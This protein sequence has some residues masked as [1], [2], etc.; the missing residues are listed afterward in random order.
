M[1]RVCVSGRY[2]H[3]VRLFVVFGGLV[4]LADVLGEHVEDARGPLGLGLVEELRAVLYVGRVPP[5]LQHDPVFQDQH[6]ERVGPQQQVGQQPDL[7][8]QQAADLLEPQ[9]VGQV[10]PAEARTA[11]HLEAGLVEAKDL[12]EVLLRDCRLLSAWPVSARSTWRSAAGSP[13]R[14]APRPLRCRPG[15]C[16]P[17]RRSSL[18]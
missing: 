2:L 6:E 17:G 11:D 14:R 1:D 3:E 5:V 12:R 16:R 13:K 18:R 15:G 8:R 10:E 4:F 7:V 9:A